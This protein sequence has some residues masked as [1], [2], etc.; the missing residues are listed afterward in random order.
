MSKTLEERHFDVRTVNRYLKKGSVTKTELEAHYKA[1]PNDEDNF[2]L[3]ILDED[4]IGIGEELSEEE[5][6][7]M[8]EIT[9]ENLDTF[10]DDSSEA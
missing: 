10:E 8:P 6:S 7:A 5:L 1:L 3:S 2:E 4:E 9:E